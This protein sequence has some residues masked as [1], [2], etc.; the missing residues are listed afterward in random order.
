MTS[1][2]INGACIIPETEIR[3]HLL[4]SY[5]NHAYWDMPLVDVNRLYIC[6]CTNT[7]DNQLSLL[8]F[9]AVMFAGI[10]STD[11][12]QPSQL[13]FATM[14]EVRE[15][16]Y[17]RVKTLY[18][19]G[20]ER[21]SVCVI[22]SLLLM[23]LWDGIS[24]DGT[25][26]W[27]WLGHSLHI[28]RA[29]GLQRMAIQP[30]MQ[31]HRQGLLKRLWWCM[32]IRDKLVALG[33]R[34]SIRIHENAHTV[35]M[36]APSDFD[37]PA[38][39]TSWIPTMEGSHSALG[40]VQVQHLAQAFVLNAKL[41]V[42]LGRILES[43]YLLLNN[44]PGT[45][46]EIESRYYPDPNASTDSEFWQCNRELEYW[47]A[48]FQSFLQTVPENIAPNAA[49]LNQGLLRLIFFSTVMAL[50][51]PLVRYPCKWSP[52]KSADEIY[53]LKKVEN[54]ASQIICTLKNLQGR[55]LASNMNGVGAAVLL[56][57]MVFHLVRI[58][59]LD[60]GEC[61]ENCRH[62]QTGKSILGEWHNQYPLA[63]FCLFLI[64]SATLKLDVF[65]ALFL[66]S[67]APGRTSK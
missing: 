46:I 61:I 8:L 42:I 19:A 36:P 66:N 25:D 67:S 47:R 65:P 49:Y 6:V 60:P 29:I 37:I 3:D 43:R 59:S 31:L 32:Y 28:S 24:G 57:A 17:N 13:G 56:P 55:K 45:A 54:A 21:D 58:K 48:N 12:L 64:E 11:Y 62:F 9:Q 63:E 16:F 35:P 5:V 1:L 7:E 50:H 18:D 41:C 27:H 51:R 10:C 22:Q 2:L 20:Y 30:D 40:R 33:S 26:A 34:R 52:S 14:R 39:E 4:D 44:S 15:V 23:T 53:S 38:S